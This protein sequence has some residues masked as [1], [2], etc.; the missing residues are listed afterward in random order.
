MSKSAKHPNFS[1]RFNNA[2]D[3]MTV[4]VG[5]SRFRGGYSI[6]KQLLLRLVVAF[7]FAL[8]MTVVPVCKAGQ[9][10]KPSDTDGERGGDDRHRHFVSPAVFQAAG[11]TAS[12]IQSTVDAFRAAL[13]DPNNGNNPGPLASGRRE[14]NWDGGGNNVT[15]DKPATPFIV[16]LNTRGAQFTT[17]GVGLSQAPPSGGPQ[18]GLA[19]LFNNPTYGTIFGTFSPLRLFTPVGSNITEALFF[20]PGTNGAVRATVRGFGAVFTDVDRGASTLI[21]YFGA[22]HRL[23]FSSSVPASPGDASL[24]F[25]GIV[26]DDP[27][28]A[29]VKITTGDTAPGPN[30]NE[31]HDI[32]MMDDFIYGEPVPAQKHAT[33]LL[34]T[35]ENARMEAAAPGTPTLTVNNG[36]GSGHHAAGTLVTVTADAPPTGHRFAGWSGDIQIL[37]NPFL[38]TTMATMPSIDVTISA[39]FDDVSSGESSE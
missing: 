9:S 31:R 17:P 12:S 37:A 39:T 15:A 23:L 16:F 30:D 28:I 6:K 20:Q 26:F 25:F 24:S 34:S 1:D 27:R 18:G 35:D 3:R 19:G 11:P 38:S 8:M 10:G 4:L 13:G 21:E 14:I 2:A 5:V 36:G 7:G 32:V 22:D 29:R 33:D